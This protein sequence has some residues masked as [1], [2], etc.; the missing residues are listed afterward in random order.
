M[1][2]L[3]VGFVVLSLLSS[4]AT[5]PESQPRLPDDTILCG[6]YYLP[7]PYFLLYRQA[8]LNRR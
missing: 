1:K 8:Y 5:F 2:L 4:C 3:I 6:S 7:A